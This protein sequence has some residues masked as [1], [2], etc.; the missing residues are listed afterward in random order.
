MCTLTRAERF[1]DARTVHN[2]HGKQTMNA[3]QEATGV[4]ASLIADLESDERS[5]KVNYMDVAK[6]AKHYGVTLDWLCGLSEDHHVNP[7]ASSELGLSEKS[8]YFLNN[9]HIIDT[10]FK[11]ITHPKQ[12]VADDM[13]EATQVW[14]AAIE[15]MNVPNGYDNSSLSRFANLYA[16]NAPALV[17]LLVSAIEKNHQIILDF[18]D[19]KEAQQ[20]PW[21][22]EKERISHYDFVRFKSAEISKAINSFLVSEFARSCIYHDKIADGFGYLFPYE[23]R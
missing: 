4:S 16:A 19:L 5:R 14:N 2:I 8:I 20:E 3:V 11:I 18:D 6:L 21:E 17:D 9:L 22:V 15:K 10:S 23:D 1:K 12:Y 7:C 13:Q